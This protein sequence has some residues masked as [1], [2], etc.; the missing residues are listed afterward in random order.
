MV[1][2]IKV[3]LGIR[4]DDKTN[5]KTV[6]KLRQLEKEEEKLKQQLEYF[7]NYVQAYRDDAEKSHFHQRNQYLGRRSRGY[8][9]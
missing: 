2:G 6:S 9:Y 8:P 5:W 1:A 4:L 7:K 3:Q